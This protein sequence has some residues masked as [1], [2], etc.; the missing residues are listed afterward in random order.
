MIENEHKELE[1]KIKVLITKSMR[2]CTG[3]IKAKELKETLFLN[4]LFNKFNIE[5]SK[6][7][8]LQKVR[9]KVQVILQNNLR[10]SIGMFHSKE[11]NELTFIREL[12]LNFKL[13]EKQP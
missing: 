13:T 2:A 6:I 12:F 11:L 9:M 1:E 5:S 7:D 8:S 3:M 10:E 4:A